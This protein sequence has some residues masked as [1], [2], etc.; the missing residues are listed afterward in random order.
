MT[1]SDKADK[2]NFLYSHS[3]YY[4]E[5][6]PENLVF[7]ANLQEFAQKVGYIVN[8][9]TAGKVTSEEAYEQVKA[10]WKKLKHSKKELGIHQEPPEKG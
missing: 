10:L 1:E 5:F 9:Q 6:N 2:E 7:N 8:L 4:G 3:K